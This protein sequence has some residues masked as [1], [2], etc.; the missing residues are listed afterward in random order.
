LK[1]SFK[2]LDLIDLGILEV[3]GPRKRGILASLILILLSIERI[4]SD[5]EILS[6]CLG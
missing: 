5:A 4:S 2:L 6:D 1:L 3:Y